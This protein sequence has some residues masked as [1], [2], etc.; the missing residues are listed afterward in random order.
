LLETHLAVIDSRFCD[1]SEYG[2]E[3]WA[4]KYGC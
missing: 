3:D 2:Q 1:E 4:V